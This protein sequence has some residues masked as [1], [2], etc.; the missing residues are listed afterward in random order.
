MKMLG[1]AA[2]AAFLL[3]GGAA[4]GADLDP[5]V[6]EAPQ[7]S[8]DPFGYLALR[9]GAAWYDDSEFL[10]AG[11][12]RVA[13]A[14]EDNPFAGTV[15]FGGQF[16]WGRV[17]AEVGFFGADVETHTTIVGG[18]VTPFAAADSFGQLSARTVMVNAFYDFD[19]G[20]IKPFVGAGVGF[21][22]V[23]AEGFGVTGLTDLLVDSDRGL[24]WQ[25]SAGLGYEVMEGLDMELGYR[26]QN[27]DGIELVS[28][29]GTASDFDFATHFVFAG[30]RAAF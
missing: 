14:Y 26:Y 25:V 29:D 12:T 4:F 13:N 19:F 17:E 28:A 24:A 10:L 2:G 8:A 15:A 7:A 23:K 1:A 9:G 16:A 6:V 22:R 21:G 27:I 3:A 11:P 18:V 5:R 20:A 30:I